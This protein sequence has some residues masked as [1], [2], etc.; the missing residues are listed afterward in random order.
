MQAYD[1]LPF[2]IEL[3]Y[4]GELFF[5]S[6]RQNCESSILS[7]RIREFF[8]DEA[9]GI[10]DQVCIFQHPPAPDGDQ[11]WIARSGSDNFDVSM[12]LFPFLLTIFFVPYCRFA[13]GYRISE[14]FRL[15]PFVFPPIMG[16]LPHSGWPLPRAT[17]PDPVA[18]FTVEEGWGTGISQYLCRIGLE[19]AAQ[20]GVCQFLRSIWFFFL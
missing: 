19:R 17:L 2:V 1:E 5:R 15:P 16:L 4:K 3:F 20:V 6:C 7:W 8:G 12:S 11:F 10:E 13:D 9:S 14:V 18:F